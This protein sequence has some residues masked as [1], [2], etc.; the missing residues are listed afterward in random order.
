MNYQQ[1]S[2]KAGSL[3]KQSF[4]RQLWKSEITQQY[5]QMPPG[6]PQPEIALA[7]QVQLI[8]RIPPKAR[9]LV[10]HQSL[11]LSEILRQMNI[12]SNNQMA[13]ILAEL[14]GGAK[15]IA[16]RAANIANFPPEEIELING[17]G[18]GEENRISPRAVCQMLI[19]IERL[20]S[21]DSLT[22]AHLFPRKGYD[23][24]VITFY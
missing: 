13:E 18:L 23:P 21:T 15:Q 12:Y 11:P 2:A 7:G 1:D 6:T 16:D 22:V 19:A 20:L 8:D 17:S 3:L 24:E 5:L 10:I 4:D 14:L 9:L